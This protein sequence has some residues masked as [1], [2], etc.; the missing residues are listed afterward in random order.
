MAGGTGGTSSPA[1]PWPRR[2]ARAAGACSWLGTRQAWRA[3]GAAAGFPFEDGGFGGVRGKGALTLALLPLRLL[4]PSGRA[5]HRDARACAR[6]G[7]G[8]GR[9]HQLSRRHDGVLLGKPLVL[10]E[11]NSVAGMANKGAGRWPTAC[12]TAF[13]ARA[14]PKHAAWGR[15]PGAR[16]VRPILRPGRA[17]RRPQ[18]PAA[19]A[20]GGRQPGRPGAQRGGAAGA[21]AD[22]CRPASARSRHAP[23]RR[24][25]DRRPARPTTAAPAC[26]PT[27]LPFI[28]DMARAYAEADL[29]ICR[30]GAITVTELCAPACPRCWCRFPTRW[31]TTRPTTRASW[32]TRARRWLM[33]QA[34]LNEARHQA[35][36]LRRHRRR[37][38]ERHRRGAA[39]PG[40]PRQGSDLADSATLRAC[41]A[42]HR[43]PRPRGRAHRRRRCG[44]HLHRGQGRQPRGAGRARAAS[45]WCRA[46]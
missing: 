1:W 11:Q 4:R 13:P 44:G 6:R 3:T 16:R 45:R 30:A 5:W 25:A 27:L 35:H 21:G 37:R 10:H 40:L 33:P 24:P 42:G 7:A 28:D 20:G 22:R 32:S 9:L 12:F 29:V 43:P 39:Q 36:P 26:R 34:E 2:C 14:A 41:R 19:R 18:R 46:R 8:H 31:T 15:Q 38:H 17:L 23:E